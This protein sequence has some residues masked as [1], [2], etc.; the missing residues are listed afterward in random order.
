MGAMGTGGTV[1][2]DLLDLELDLLEAAIKHGKHNQAS[3][4]RRTARRRAYSAAYSSARAG[5]A[6]PAD[7]RAAAR[8]AGLS[9]QGERDVRLGRLREAAQQGGQPSTDKIRKDNME[10]LKKL[11]TGTLNAAE[12]QQARNYSSN[13]NNNQLRQIRSRITQLREDALN[14]PNGAEQAYA[15]QLTLRV[16]DE[17]Q[18]MKKRK[19]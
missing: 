9:R 17:A 14:Q 11:D 5:G 19:D 10:K 1:M 15:H 8:E 7:A 18:K 2:S 6:S 12:M 4:G 13:F 3:H 16:L